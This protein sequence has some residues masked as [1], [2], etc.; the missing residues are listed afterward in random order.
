[1][2]PLKYAPRA[3]FCGNVKW[4]CGYC[5]TIN[6]HHLDYT[7]WKF[8]CRGKN[9]SKRY[10]IGLTFIVHSR[11]SAGCLIPKDYIVPDGPDLLD[12]FPVVKLREWRRVP[13]A[14]SPFPPAH[15]LVEEE[16]E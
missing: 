1:M 16:L 9:C 7:S 4:L 5:G 10:H 14:H 11:Q 2:K 15:E 6:K 12:S 13:L 8:E 3:Q